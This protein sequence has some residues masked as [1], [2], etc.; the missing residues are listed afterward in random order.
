MGPIG[1]EPTGEITPCESKL[2]SIGS[3]STR[4]FGELTE[5]GK[6]MTAA[7]VKAGDTVPKPTAGATSHAE[8]LPSGV[9]FGVWSAPNPYRAGGVVAPHRVPRGAFGEA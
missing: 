2:T 6:Q 3:L 1:V 8:D 5:E 9:V 4:S 7:K